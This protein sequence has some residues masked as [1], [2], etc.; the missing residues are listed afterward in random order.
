MPAISK[1]ENVLYH[2]A[3]VFSVVIQLV[4][5]CV[6]TDERVAEGAAFTEVCQS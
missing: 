1:Y 3:K 6:K 2:K 4:M 5:M